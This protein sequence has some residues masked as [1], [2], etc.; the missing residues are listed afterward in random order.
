M[1]EDG[2]PTEPLEVRAPH[3]ARQLEIDWADG[4]M[5]LYPHGV[6]RGFCPCAHCQ[7]HEGAIRFVPGGDRDE[8]GALELT[9][10]HEVGNYALQLTWGDGHSTGIYSFRFLRRLCSCAG[11]L[12][13]TAATERAFP[14]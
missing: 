14:R 7:G 5:G 6:L 13:D 8:G 4:H 10:I 3:G 9:A 12:G 11:C 2:D 1:S